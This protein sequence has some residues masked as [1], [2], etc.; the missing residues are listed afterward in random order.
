MAECCIPDGHIIALRVTKTA[1][2]PKIFVPFA[3]VG[4]VVHDNDELQP[5]CATEA[6]YFNERRKAGEARE[7][8]V[9]KDREY[10]RKYGCP[11]HADKKL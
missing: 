7:V 9:A 10:E 6:A 11:R 1:W 8:Q 2:P 4:R 5:M 3:A